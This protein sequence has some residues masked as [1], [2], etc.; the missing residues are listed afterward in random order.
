MLCVAFV[1][2]QYAVISVL[3]KYV[4]YSISDG[5]SLKTSGALV[6]KNHMIILRYF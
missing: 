3:D 1:T 6:S 5:H 4:S 2:K